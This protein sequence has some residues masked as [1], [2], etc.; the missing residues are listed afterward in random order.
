MQEEER[1]GS[2]E[3]EREDRRGWKKDLIL[4]QSLLAASSTLPLLF[5]SASLSQPYGQ[6]SCSD[7]VN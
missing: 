2:R 3:G 7:W 5:I 6:M 4:F 1:E